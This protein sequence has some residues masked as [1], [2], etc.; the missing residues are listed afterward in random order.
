MYSF[1]QHTVFATE[2]TAPSM[3]FAFARPLGMHYYSACSK[4][5]AITFETEMLVGY[6][7]FIS[8]ARPQLRNAPSNQLR[9]QES[10]IFAD[11][12]YLLKPKLCR[13]CCSFDLVFIFDYLQLSACSIRIDS[14]LIKLGLHM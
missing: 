5:K 13:F 10:Q 7:G 12:R 8:S 4:K 3:D 9:F 11:W 1:I 14:F 2:R 6:C